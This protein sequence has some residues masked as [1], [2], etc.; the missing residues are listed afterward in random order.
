[1]AYKVFVAGEEALAA[2]VNSYLMSQAVP[3]FSSASQRTS[4]LTAPV[5][6]QTSMLDTNPGGLDYWNGSAWIPASAGAEL[7]YSQVT[8]IKAV[9]QQAANVADVII[10]PPAARVYDGLPVMAEFFAPNVLAPANGAIH[11]SIYEAGITVAELGLAAIN[12]GQFSLP[13]CLRL[14]FTPTAGS[15]AYGVGAWVSTGSG[16]VNAGTGAGGAYVPAF[17]RIT[18]A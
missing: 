5:L 12:A 18:K 4:Q 11:F 16:T 2:D 9:T 13:V 15:H 1:M 7:Q 8:A 6:N 3:R 17:L 14:R 10:P